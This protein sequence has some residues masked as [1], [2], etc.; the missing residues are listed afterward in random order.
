MNITTE[1][2]FD[3]T[4][5][6]HVNAYDD[7]G[8]KVGFIDAEIG[9][10]RVEITGIYVEEQCRRLCIADIMLDELTDL[11]YL[12]GMGLELTMTYRVDKQLESLDAFIKSRYDFIVV[13][14]DFEYVISPE[15][16]QKCKIIQELMKMKERGMSR[17]HSLNDISNEDINHVVKR[18]REEQIDIR[19]EE[20]TIRNYYDEKLSFVALEEDKIMSAVLSREVEDS[21]YGK[22]I[23][24]SAV[25]CDQGCELL[26]MKI[27]SEIMDKMIKNYPEHKLRFVTVSEKAIAM[28]EK[29]FDG[30][31]VKNKINKAIWLSI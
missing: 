25:V 2:I 28:A 1:I 12:N 27:L 15:K 16:W 17:V 10:V 11:L 13:E 31:I 20:E 23:E 3:E 6:M 19:D 24:I 21:E 29:I 8:R 14:E 18:F 9:E 26:L 7:F 30:N 22:V 4:Y 5:S